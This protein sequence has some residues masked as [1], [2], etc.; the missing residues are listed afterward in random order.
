MRT[1]S[2]QGIVKTKYNYIIPTCIK[3][4]LKY[5]IQTLFDYF[6]VGEKTCLIQIFTLHIA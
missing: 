3:N 1:V 2:L 4:V 5:V 6:F